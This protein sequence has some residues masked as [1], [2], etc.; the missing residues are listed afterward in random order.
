MDP[1]PGVLAL[2]RGEEVFTRRAPPAPLER[3]LPPCAPEALWR[4]ARSLEGAEEPC[5]WTA[6]LGLAQAP[7]L[8]RTL[9]L[10]RL[11]C[12]ALVFPV[13]HAPDEAIASAGHVLEIPDGLER[14]RGVH[15]AG[16]HVALELDLDPLPDAMGLEALLAFLSFQMGDVDA[17]DRITLGPGEPDHQEALFQRLLEALPPIGLIAE[18]LD[19]EGATPRRRQALAVQ[20]SQ[21]REARRVGRTLHCGRAWLNVDILT[22]EIRLRAG[23]ASVIE[24]PGM[25]PAV[26]LDGRR[27]DAAAG[28]W[29]CTDGPGGALL[30][31]C[32]MPVAMARL[33][34]T[35]SP[36]PPAGFSLQVAL[37]LERPGEIGDLQ[38]EGINQRYT[39]HPDHPGLTSEPGRHRLVERLELQAPP[40]APAVS[41]R[42][43]DEHDFALVICPPWETRMPPLWPAMLAAHLRAAGL[44]GACHDVN[45]Q[46]HRGAATDDRALW[47]MVDFFTWQRADE[48]AGIK[49]RLGGAMKAAAARILTHSPRVVGFT[50][51]LASLRCSIW[52]AELL[53]T[54]D[55]EVKIVMGG[56][57]MFWTDEGDKGVVPTSLIDHWTGEEIDAGGV[58]DVVCRGEAD[59]TVAPLFMAL[60]QGVDPLEVP[61]TV[62][63][64]DGVWRARAPRPPEDLDAL[65]IPDYSDLDPGAFPLNA[66]PLLTSRG[67]T[68]GCAFCNDCRL[69]GSYRRRSAE[70]VFRE[71]AHLHRRYGTYTFHVVDL[72]LN[73]DLAQLERLCDLIIEADI[74]IDWGGQAII[75]PDMEPGLL[76][77]MER[78][79]CRSLTFGVESF[80]QDVVDAMDKRFHVADAKRQLR[81][82]S[83]AGISPAI[84]LLVGFPGETEQGFQET[85]DALTE[86]KDHIGRIQAINVC[87][88]TPRS[89]LWRAPDRYGVHDNMP[90]AW[91]RWTGPARN[92]YAVRK[93]RLHRLMQHVTALGLAPHEQNLYDERALR[94][95]RVALL[96]A[97]GNER[98]QVEPGEP[99]K[100]AIHYEVLSP[101][102]DPL[103]RVQILRDGDDLLA[104]G[105]N[106]ARAGFRCG[107]LATG[108]GCATL[109]LGALRLAP[110]GYRITAGV[111]PDEDS[112]SPFDVR[113]GAL[114]LVVRGETHPD[115]PL[116]DLDMQLTPA[117]GAPA[118]EFSPLEEEAVPEL[119]P[120][121]PLRA[122]LLPA[123]ATEEPARLELWLM[124]Q[125]V[126]VYQRR[127]DV[128][129]V[130]LAQAELHLGCDELPLLPG[131]YAL[132]VDIHARGASEALLSQTRRFTVTGDR[133]SGGGIV[134]HAA[135]W[136]LDH[137]ASPPP[138]SYWS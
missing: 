73:G 40:A 124:K 87:H 19:G 6:R 82:A 32:A 81:Q 133:T 25:S 42:P 121:A 65:P 99:L 84:N 79:G 72:M 111:W 115:R 129:G 92:S 64:R 63:R 109:D 8:A 119:G 113:H 59:L 106:M 105:H 95:A 44:R 90:E 14:L 71:V 51:T 16:L 104:Y 97:E 13:G 48:F 57:G 55:P 107:E 96:D 56:P 69:Q 85:M 94:L 135:S 110:G 137:E 18:Q 46:I 67:C 61:G 134:R 60:L 86:V 31:E 74:H 88:I 114:D 26:V 35:F 37:M 5:L 103:F 36:A 27:V 12:A 68:R 138:E 38:L 1:P 127:L 29:C 22:R 17:V 39:W 80:S 126:L 49:S 125:G 21:L 101:V 76:R 45:N 43:A 4:W 28:R 15:D 120:D 11:G 66:L 9:E 34:L 3:D 132:A 98:E 122:R 41:R 7:P 78:A 83:E 2:A 118:L 91:Y 130:E 136:A 123:R 75:H 20:T 70:H 24:A 30:L 52:L 128:P 116:V 50:T 100:V 117:T 112:D 33:W 89:R 62:V 58:I 23:E 131:E 108:R 93:E 47:E 77:K 54:F 102:E 53:K 10:R